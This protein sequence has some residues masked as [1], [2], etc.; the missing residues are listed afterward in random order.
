MFRFIFAGVLALYV[1]AAAAS[2][3]PAFVPPA[4]WVKVAPDPQLKAFESGPA[5]QILLVDNQA[6]LAHDG[7]HLYH[8][9]V[10]KILTP[11]GLSAFGTARWTWDPATEDAQI[12]ALKIIRD[13]KT[14]DVLGDGHTV[15]VLRRETDLE[16]AI[17]D[18]RLTATLQME[19]LQIGDVVDLS[20]TLIRHDPALKDHS[21]FLDALGQLKVGRQRMRVFGTTT[22]RSDGQRRP[23]SINPRS[24]TPTNE[25]SF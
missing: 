7:D 24:R 11:D 2:D 18:G 20:W 23:A 12:H 19:G 16:R 25:K 15:T 14:I 5:V 9:H 17:L 10:A 13:G 22:S 21:Q 1:T 6:Y 8:R 3:K 4:S